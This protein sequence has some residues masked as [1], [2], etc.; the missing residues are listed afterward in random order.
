MHLSCGSDDHRDEEGGIFIMDKNEEFDTRQG[1]FGANHIFRGFFIGSIYVVCNM[2][3]FSM[4][5]CVLHAFVFAC[6]HLLQL[7]R[8]LKVCIKLICVC[9]IGGCAPLSDYRVLVAC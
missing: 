6:L 5:M 1:T 2:Y 4:D 7:C 3:S 9:L 8:C